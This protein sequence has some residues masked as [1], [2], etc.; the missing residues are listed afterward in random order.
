MAGKV[1]LPVD[2]ELSWGCPSKSSVSPHVDL[3][4]GVDLLTGTIAWLYL[5][6]GIPWKTEYSKI[7]ESK[8]CP[9]FRPGLGTSFVLRNWS[10][11]SEQ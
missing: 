11:Q 5:C 3:S 2:E 9:S 4:A 10:K 6:T 8:S 7:Q 1:V